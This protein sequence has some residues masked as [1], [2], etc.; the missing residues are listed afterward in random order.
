MVV[1][2]PKLITKTHVPWSS[3]SPVNLLQSMSWKITIKIEAHHQTKEAFLNSCVVYWRVL[4]KL[5]AFWGLWHEWPYLSSCWTSLPPWDGMGYPGR[6]PHGVAMHTASPVDNLWL[7]IAV[8]LWIIVNQWLIVI[9]HH[10]HY[11]PL[12]FLI[13]H[14]RT[15]H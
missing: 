12:L 3:Y 14:W 10:Y 13:N 1:L 15:I 6:V 8:I 9:N 11:Y 5:P 4:G 7:L 2:H